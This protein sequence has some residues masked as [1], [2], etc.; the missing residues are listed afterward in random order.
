MVIKPET[1]NL[2]EEALNHFGNAEEMWKNESFQKAAGEATSSTLFGIRAITEL[3]KELKMPE[4]FEIAVNALL[5]GLERLEKHYTPKE[6]IEWARR[7]L[8]R[9]SDATPEDTFRPLR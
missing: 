9:L 5:D 4:L 1:S 8:K 2:W 3:S 7:T 6:T